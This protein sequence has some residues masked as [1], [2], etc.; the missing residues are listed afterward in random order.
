MTTDNNPIIEITTEELAQA[1]ISLRIATILGSRQAVP[2]EHFSNWAWDDL[3]EDES[4]EL[5]CLLDALN[6]ER[7]VDRLWRMTTA[8]TNVEVGP[9]GDLASSLAVRL[10]QRLTQYPS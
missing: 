1:I 10:H 6:G 8:L 5:D 2:R 4:T 3:D 7:E 9:D